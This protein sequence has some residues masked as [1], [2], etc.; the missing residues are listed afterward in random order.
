MIRLGTVGTSAICSKF[1]SGVRLTDE[2]ILSAVYSRKKETGLSFAK[3][4]NCETVFTDLKEMAE[5]G[6]IDAVYIASP[7]AF[8]KSQ[9]E[10][11]L[12][13]NIHVI[14]EKPIV[15]NADDYIFLKNKADKNSL[16]FMEA[17]IPIFSKQYNLIK[18]ALKE[19]GKIEMAKINFCQ[20]S[21]RLDS[22]L[23]GQKVNIFDMSL[24]AG[25]LNDLGV[26]C[27][28]GACDL[29]GIPK[30]IEA[31]SYFFSNGADKSGYA[32]FDYGDFPALLTYSKSC[33][34]DTGSEIIGSDGTLKISM[35]SQYSGVTLIKSGKE[36]EIFST[37]S[38]AE[39]MSGEAQKFADFILN[40][41]EN[42]KE[43]NEKSDLCL[44]VHRCMDLIKQKSGL[45]YPEI[46]K[47]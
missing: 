30:N 7:N 40:L 5:S 44:N 37:P 32:L 27:V 28:Y 13:N 45:K 11:F 41:E 22:F 24:H 1:L 18:Q 42:E 43:Y 39:L 47:G 46:K 15:T 23:S 35:I 12:N 34:S 29:L 20:R 25:T 10:I 26:Y 4:N 6:L 33:Q 36:K 3:E 8:H 21:S 16:V 2:F 19:I 31:E 17:I 9:C 14:C 38:K